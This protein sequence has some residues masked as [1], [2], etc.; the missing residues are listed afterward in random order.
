MERPK[1]YM[2][3]EG[4]TLSGID[5]EIRGDFTRMLPRLKRNNLLGEALV[6]AVRTKGEDRPLTIVDAT[7]GLGEDALLLAAAGHRVF[8][9]ERDPVIA[10]LLKDALNRANGDPLLKDIAG[11]MTLFCEDSIP[12]LSRLSFRPDA[13]FLDPMFPG[14]QKSG[15]VKKKFQLLHLLEKPCEDEKALLSAAFLARPGKI[16]V[17]RPENGP[18]LSGKKPDYELKGK[19]IR[20]DVYKI[21]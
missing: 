7:A 5:M 16:I 19:N 14:R 21:S 1:L 9:F 12:A 8:L 4:L 15:L 10:A 2:K 6:K 17:K 13:V 3:P 11:R 20:Y 18:Y